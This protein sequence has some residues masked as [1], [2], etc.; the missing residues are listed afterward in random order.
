[1]RGRFDGS[2]SLGLGAMK[3]IDVEATVWCRCRRLTELRREVM[4]REQP[5]RVAEFRS[6]REAIE[7]NHSPT[8]QLNVRWWRCNGRNG[9]ALGFNPA[10]GRPQRDHPTPTA[11][12]PPDRLRASLSDMVGPYGD[13]SPTPLEQDR[14]HQGEGRMGLLREPVTLGCGRWGRSH[15]FEA[16]SQRDSSGNEVTIPTRSASHERTIGISWKHTDSG[17]RTVDVSSRTEVVL[18]SC[19]RRQPTI[20]LLWYFYK[21]V[22]GG[23]GQASGWL[24]TGAVR[25]ERSRRG[26]PWSRPHLWPNI[27]TSSTSARMSVDGGAPR[28]RGGLGPRARS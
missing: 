14:L 26:D 10:R 13:T 24:T 16:R 21:R 12:R 5:A 22:D 27:R 2:S 4:S 6:D 8:A 1:M 11:V 18:M 9:D 17:R 28:V 25:M 23:G 19:N 7:E 15:Y 20:R 3:V